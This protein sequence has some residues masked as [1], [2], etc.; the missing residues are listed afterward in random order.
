MLLYSKNILDKI[1]FEAIFMVSN[2]YKVSSIKK[3]R[4]WC[5][6][7][8]CQFWWDRLNVQAI[9]STT[10]SIRLVFHEERRLE[11]EWFGQVSFKLFIKSN[12][13]LQPIDW[14]GNIVLR[15]AL[16]IKSNLSFIVIEKYRMITNDSRCPFPYTGTWKNSKIKI[17]VKLKSEYTIHCAG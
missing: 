16:Y 7:L 13:F 12:F 17:L 14:S 3:M 4:V 6:W 2:I 8:L 1:S 11:F 15:F 10:C 5:G 9:H